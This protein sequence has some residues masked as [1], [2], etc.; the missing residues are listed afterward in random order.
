M[1][2]LSEQVRRH[3]ITELAC[4]RTPTEIVDSVREL[5]GIE[6]RRQKVHSYDPNG[7]RGN[8]VA[9]KWRDLFEVTRKAFLEDTSKIPIANKAVRLQRLERMAASAERMGNI[10][11]A[12]SLMEQA[13]KEAGGSYTNKRE[14]S[15]PG[16]GAI[17]TKIEVEFVDAGGGS[18]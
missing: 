15:G 11:L 1:A 7:V 12:S 3:I 4:Y 8:E 17:P 9:K 14:F 2:R 6:V 10:A 18:E 13:A 5:F 16:G